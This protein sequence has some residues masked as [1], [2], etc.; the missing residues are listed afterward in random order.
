MAVVAVGMTALDGYNFVRLLETGTMGKFDEIIFV[1]SSVLAV[2]AMGAGVTVVSVFSFGTLPLVA[3]VIIGVGW[4]AINGAVVAKMISNEHRAKAEHPTP[5]AF[6]EA[7]KQEE[8]GQLESKV[9]E[10]LSEMFNKLL[11]A[12]QVGIMNEC[13]PDGLRGFASYKAG[14]AKAVQSYL[15][16]QAIAKEHAAR[17]KEHFNASLQAFAREYFTRPQTA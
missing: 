15:E 10:E 2:L 5:E 17:E 1:V 14:L 8:A 12:D 4:L 16:K 3:L 11:N 9:L 7:L 6:L 13:Q